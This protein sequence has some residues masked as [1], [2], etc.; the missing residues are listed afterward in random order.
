MSPWEGGYAP[1]DGVDG[2]EMRRGEARGANSLMTVAATRLGGYCSARR[3]AR[4]F[5]TFSKDGGDGIGG[6]R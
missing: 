5:N 6:R 4:R 1:R 2:E 3:G